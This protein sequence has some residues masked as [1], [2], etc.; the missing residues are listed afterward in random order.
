[1]TCP[2]YFQK[3]I[4]LYARLSL[5]KGWVDWVTD[6]VRKLEACK[7]GLWVDLGA[8]VNARRKELRSVGQAK[9]PESESPAQTR[10]P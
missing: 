3:Q 2:D 7:S 6:H 1:M 8:K 10:L 5:Q 4:D 9:V